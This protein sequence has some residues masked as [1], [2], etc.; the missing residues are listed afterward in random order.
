MVKFADDTTVTGLISNCDE[1]AYRKEI[2]SLIN[3]CENNNLILNPSKTKEMIIDY[4]KKKEPIT[5]VFINN[6]C[7]EIVN[8]FKFLGTTISSD[9]NWHFNTKLIHVL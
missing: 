3:W 2:Q 1:T 5:P 6:E 4:R 9:L 7:N 8:S